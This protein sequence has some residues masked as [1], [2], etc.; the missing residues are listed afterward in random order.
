MAPTPRP[1]IRRPGKLG[2]L[3]LELLLQVLLLPPELL[4]GAP[5]QT[6]LVPSAVNAGAMVESTGLSGSSIILCSSAR[7][8]M[9]S[10]ARVLASK[11]VGHTMWPVLSIVST[12]KVSVSVGPRRCS[13]PESR[14]RAAPAPRLGKAGAEM[15]GCGAGLPSKSATSA[16]WIL[17]ADSH[18]LVLS[19]QS[20][21]LIRYSVRLPVLRDCSIRSTSYTLP[22]PIWSP[23]AATPSAAAPAGRAHPA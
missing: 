20:S 13:A 5:F 23:P 14:A 4:H 15:R 19:S 18:V 7:A 2:L 17:L 16:G 12:K 6:A 1:S 9:R 8:C 11:F 21:H 10:A 3:L 22:V